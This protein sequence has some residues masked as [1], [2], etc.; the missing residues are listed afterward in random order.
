MKGGLKWLVGAAVLSL[1][2]MAYYLV[3]VRE[4][5]VRV[6]SGGGSVLH[7][8]ECGHEWDDTVKVDII[9][10]IINVPEF[11]DCQRLVEKDG[12]GGYKYTVLAAVFA[13]STL[14]GLIDALGPIAVTSAGGS[15]GSITGDSAGVPVV[16]VVP[17]ATAVAAAVVYSE[18]AYGR[19]GIEQGLNC[20][21]V[22][23][24]Q[25]GTPP[26]EAWGARM[27][28]R[29]AELTCPVLTRDNLLPG[30]DL[31][32]KSFTSVPG[33][34]SPSDYP[35]VA[36]WDWDAAHDGQYIGIKCGAA[37][38]EV[39]EKGFTPSEP[40]QG[41]DEAKDRFKRVLAIKGWHDRQMLAKGEGTSLVPSG[42][43]GIIWP[44]PDLGS[45]VDYSKWVP[46]ANVVLRAAAT[47]DAVVDKYLD[48][49]NFERTG[50]AH[51][52]EMEVRNKGDQWTAKLR[53]HLVWGIKDQRMRRLKYRPVEATFAATYKV[54]GVARWRWLTDDEGSWTRC[55]EGCCE[56]SF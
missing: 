34:T 20:L 42:V 28:P 54:P 35:D 26:I 16:R 33:Y 14:G 50:F 31:E 43:E 49:Y 6:V 18:G 56:M 51:P 24:Y 10:D 46:S 7:V 40:M 8:P 52:V 27:V 1:A 38:C 9:R 36:R 12:Q 13:S 44:D 25:T 29:G 17:A 15:G 5:P 3:R 30:L 39:G 2:V 19:L 37:W 53:R 22:W 21:Y 55:T 48:R 11:H 23:R 4:L 41:V 47:E 45:A 32:V